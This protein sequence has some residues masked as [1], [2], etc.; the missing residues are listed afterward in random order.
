[1]S[2]SQICTL[3]FNGMRENEVRSGSLFACPEKRWDMVNDD[4]VKCPL[5]G[6]FTQVERSDLLE[7][8]K[9]PRSR[10]QIE[11]CIAEWLKSPGGRVKRSGCDAGGA[12]FPQGPS[13]LESLR[14]DVASELQGIDR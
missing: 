11:K 7:A 1:M 10:E 4:L 14:P 6:G 12:R 9:Q 13:S 3:S 5:C 8:L 2:L